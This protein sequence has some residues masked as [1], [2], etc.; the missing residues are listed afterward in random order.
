[1]PQAE[2]AAIVMELIADDVR[3]TKGRVGGGDNAFELVDGALVER[4]A[5]VPLPPAPGA[6]LD[7]W[8]MLLGRS[9][10]VR[11]RAAR[12]STGTRQ[13]QHL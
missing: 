11:Y 12:L 13:L 5:P 7:I 10:A 3:R 6:T 1:M 4:N 2:P 8:R 9:R